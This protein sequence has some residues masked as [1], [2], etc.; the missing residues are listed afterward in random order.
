MPPLRP[1]LLALLAP[2]V[3]LGS[4]PAAEAGPHPYFDDRGTLEWHTDLDRACAAARAQGKLVFVDS[5]RSLCGNCRTLVSRVLPADGVRAR[6]TAAAVG[7]ADDCD[8]TDP[9]VSAL[10]ARWLPDAR[11]LPLVGFVTPD[12]QWVTG[13]SGGTDAA[14]VGSHLARAEAAAARARATRQARDEEQR[15]AEA[16]RLAR[17]QAERRA[18]AAPPP[19]AP[20]P[21]CTV[22][23]PRFAAEDEAGCDE[24]CPGGVCVA[25]RAAA[26]AVAPPAP[27]PP[28][29]PAPAPAPA[30]TPAPLPPLARGDDLPPPA[31]RS[32]PAPP[33]APARASPAPFARPAVPASRT[34]SGG[35]SRPLLASPART[36]ASAAA[37]LPPPR[38]VRPPSVLERARAA[39]A[40]RAWGE[41]A[42]LG[43]AAADLPR[44]PERSEVEAL[45]QRAHAWT[46]DTMSAAVAAAEEGRP[47][48][49]LR[50]LEQVRREMGDRP[51]ARDVERGVLAI[52]RLARI[53]GSP[54]GGDEPETL[55][56][57]AYADFRGSRWAA[58]FR[59]G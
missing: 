55:R 31:P 23:A 3:V 17:E 54:D 53:Q 30:P 4:V 18:R 48:E 33:P 40:A 19:C 39:A 10:F 12:L 24:E 49:A 35:G 46:L 1:A 37:T 52:E 28:A 11:M 21:P 57:Q 32:P 8:R 43:D 16:Q 36:P 29:P 45:A 58:L 20:P 9:R 6:M 5:G 41:L 59:R 38:H 25:P 13:W 22:P 42:R 34:A 7:F 50:L 27:P 15:R 44:G 47:G 14:T 26:R 2:L 56:R 51:V